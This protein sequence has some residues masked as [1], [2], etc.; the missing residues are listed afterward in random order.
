VRSCLEQVTT[1]LEC[2]TN[3]HHAFIIPFNPKIPTSN[4][5]STSYKMATRVA[6]HAGSWYSS[7]ASTLSSELD[8]WL[9]QVPTSIDGKE[10]PVPGARVIIAP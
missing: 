9:A 3:N 10:L 2:L 5:N 4:F 6:S 8:E 7:R 1:H